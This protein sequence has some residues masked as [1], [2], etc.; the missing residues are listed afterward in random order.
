MLLGSLFQFPDVRVG[1]VILALSAVIFMR[2][3]KVCVQE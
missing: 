2:S 3:C 1:L